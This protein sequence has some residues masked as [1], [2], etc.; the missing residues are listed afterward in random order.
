MARTSCSCRPRCGVW[1][2]GDDWCCS[3]GSRVVP[4][5][6]WVKAGRGEGITP[7]LDSAAWCVGAAGGLP[8]PHTPLPAESA[9]LWGQQPWPCMGLVWD[10]AGPRIAWHQVQARPPYPTTAAPRHPLPTALR[11]TLPS[12]FG[13]MRGDKGRNGQR[14]ASSLAPPARLSPAWWTVLFFW[15]RVQLSCVA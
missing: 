1:T 3:W 4:E 13:L 5:W 2:L 7:C 10:L 8:P 11:R 15:K 6:C 12:S 14:A 9:V